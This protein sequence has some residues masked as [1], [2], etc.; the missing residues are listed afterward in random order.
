[1]LNSLHLRL[2]GAEA[3]VATD[4]NRS[5]KGNNQSDLAVWNLHRHNRFFSVIG[6]FRLK[7]SVLT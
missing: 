7:L 3:M 2:V 1:M 4:E 6:K 5:V